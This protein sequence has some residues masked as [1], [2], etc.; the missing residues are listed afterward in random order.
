M[1]KLLEKYPELWAALDNKSAV[2]I[3][4]QGESNR[5]ER[6]RLTKERQAKY[7]A[8][9]LR[10]AEIRASYQNNPLYLEYQLKRLNRE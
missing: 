10:R 7:E 2:E 1:S 8:S 6:E 5:L 9:E 4:E 3:L